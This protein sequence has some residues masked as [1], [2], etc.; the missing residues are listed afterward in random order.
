MFPTPIKKRT[1]GWQI[2][3]QAMIPVVLIMWLLPLLAV[4]LFSIKPEADF[5]AGDY[6]SLPS[7]LEGFKNY[8]KVFFESDMPRYMWNSIRIT[9]PTV[10]GCM[11]LSSFFKS[12]KIVSEENT[13]HGFFTNT[14]TI[15]RLS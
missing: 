4:M 14:D 7:S 10:I 9:V 5:V 2:G 12:N 1:R 8:G 13:Y 15:R 6:W 3:Y 11:I